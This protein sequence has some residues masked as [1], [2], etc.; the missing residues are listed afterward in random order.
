MVSQIHGVGLR[1]LLIWAVASKCGSAFSAGRPSFRL[2]STNG[3]PTT[4]NSVLDEKVK[5]VQ[6][7]TEGSKP[8][9]GEVQACVDSL[10]Q[11]GEQM[12]VGQSSSFNGLL[13]G[14]W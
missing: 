5:L 7:C 12:G 9:L 13:N 14:E 10:E 11:V 6:I 2:S 3:E 4:T 1:A 8:S